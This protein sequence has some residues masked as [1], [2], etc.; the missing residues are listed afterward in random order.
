MVSVHARMHE[1]V[2]VA[3]LPLVEL[4]LN[5]QVRPRKGTIRWQILLRK[6]KSDQFQLVN[7]TCKQHSTTLLLASLTKKVTS[8]HR[9][10][11]VLLA[12]VGAR[13]VLHMQPKSLLKKQ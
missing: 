8:F 13:R 6:S 10:A 4:N 12:S 3:R 9:A 2:R 5:Q 1:L 11:Q 7:Y